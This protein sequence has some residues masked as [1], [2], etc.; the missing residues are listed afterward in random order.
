MSA[1]CTPGQPRQ[2]RPASGC[3]IM[4]QHSNIDQASAN[5]SMGGYMDDFKDANG[6]TMLHHIAK[7]PGAAA[8]IRTLVAAGCVVNAQDSSG[9]SVLMGAAAS[10]AAD[11]VEVLLACEAD[12]RAVDDH[13]GTALHM[14]AAHSA[15]ACAQ[16]LLAAAPDL[17]AVST[18]ALIPLHSLSPASAAGVTPVHVAASYGH[19]AVLAL[20]LAAG[21][22][23]DAVSERGS[24]ALRYAVLHGH[25]AA[26]QMLLDHGADVGGARVNFNGKLKTP[27]G[28]AFKHQQLA[29]ARL[30]VRHGADVSNVPGLEQ[31]NAA[32]MAQMWQEDAK[33]LAQLHGMVP[34]LQDLIVKMACER[35]RL[36]Q[37]REAWQAGAAGPVATAAAAACSGGVG[38]E[39]PVGREGG[40]KRT[41]LTS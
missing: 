4:Q 26:V 9:V 27:L 23:A 15:V 18:T 36:Q 11:N 35:K 14:A 6:R 24:T 7:K 5:A 16:L 40:R 29:L 22:D 20:L 39:Q 10:N 13:G 3:R 34:A 1:P 41:R 28:T 12:A 37:E 8:L 32:A 31:G 17:H 19:T 33:E 30:L 38:D 25:T 2:P 21:A